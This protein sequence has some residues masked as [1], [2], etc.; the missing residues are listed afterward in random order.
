MNRKIF[1]GRPGMSNICA[2]EVC[3]DDSKSY[4]FD[5][6]RT[7]NKGCIISTVF[8]QK[9]RISNVRRSQLWSAF[10]L[11]LREFQFPV[12]N[13]RI[14]TLRS[15][16]AVDKFYNFIPKTINTLQDIRFS[17]TLSV[18]MVQRSQDLVTLSV[19]IHVIRIVFH[20]WYGLPVIR[21]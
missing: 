13:I 2:I 5:F 18:E 21:S 7:A 20:P 17:L 8:G 10:Q 4:S 3:I 16:G 11:T 1:V 9:S 15:R 6:G 12:H 14:R 19:V